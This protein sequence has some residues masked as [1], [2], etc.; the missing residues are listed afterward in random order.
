M[1]TFKLASAEYFVCRLGG[2]SLNDAMRFWKAKFE[3]INHF[4]RDVTHHPALKELEKCVEEHWNTIQPITVQEALQETNIEKRRVMFD[5]IGVANLFKSL[6]PLLLD[7]QVISKV[8]KRWNNKNEVYEYTFNDTY[9]L[10]RLDGNQLFRNE[11]SLA[12]PIY[13]VRCWCTSTNREY[14]IYVPQD[15]AE[16]NIF[17][18]SPNPDAVRAIAW[19]IQIDITHPKRILRQGDIIVV[20]QSPQSTDAVPYHLSKEQYLRLMYSET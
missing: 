19:T 18:S 12:N 15:I 2:F 3:S 6:D 13:A 5:C 8:L 20:E 16:G 1:S 10:Y 7:K 9:E 14:W 4:K 17:Q 11:R